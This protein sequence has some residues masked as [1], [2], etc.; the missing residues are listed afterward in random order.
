MATS[1][2]YEK[3]QALSPSETKKLWQT[4]HITTNINRDS[5]KIEWE[6]SLAC[7]DQVCI[8]LNLLT[9]VKTRQHKAVPPLLHLK[10]IFY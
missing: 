9:I 4:F 7:G 8:R 3:S 5:S 10:Q 2:K 1:T 6:F